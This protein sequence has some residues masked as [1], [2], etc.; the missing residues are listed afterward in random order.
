[1][2][3]KVKVQV[4]TLGGGYRFK[5]H[6]LC[7][8]TRNDP[9]ALVKLL[10]GAICADLG[11]MCADL[12]NMCSKLGNMCSKLGNMS[13]DLGKYG[14]SSKIHSSNRSINL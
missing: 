2:N 9:Y 14:Q 8:L 10:N 6:F 13:T 12:G 1:M 4:T 3:F 7:D 5:F 11:N